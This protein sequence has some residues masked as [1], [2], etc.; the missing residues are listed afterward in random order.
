MPKKARDMVHVLHVLAAWVEPDRLDPETVRRC[1]SALTRWRSG[2]YDVIV[3]SGGMFRAG[4]ERSAGEMMAAWF[5]E[6]GVPDASLLVE[7]G[8]V[9][10]F[11]NAEEALVILRRA[12]GNRPLRIHVVSNPLH[13]LRAFVLYARSLRR[14]VRLR[15]L[16]EVPGPRQ[17][18]LECAPIILSAV[19]GPYA[20]PFR[21]IRTQ[22]RHAPT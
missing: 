13:A 16:W 6:S 3:P 2:G 12:Y 8:S 15:P 10:T 7:D 18:L 20:L 5:V 17:A 19:L 22:R 11:E 14:F 21:R 1:Q 9:D 4:Q